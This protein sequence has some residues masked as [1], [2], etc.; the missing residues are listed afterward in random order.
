MLR[1]A[2]HLQTEMKIAAAMKEYD[3]NVAAA[4][5]AAKAAAAAASAGYTVPPGAQAQVA[6]DLGMP[7]TTKLIIGGVAALALFMLM[8]RR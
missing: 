6:R 3:A 8:R 7:M 5:A 4:E 2:E 1:V